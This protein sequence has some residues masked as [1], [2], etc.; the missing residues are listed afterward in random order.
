MTKMIAEYIKG[1]AIC[2]QMKP[3][4]HPTRTPL[5]SISTNPKVKPFSQCLVDFITDLPQVEEYDSIMVIVDH[6]LSKGIS[7]T[8]CSK[9][10]NSEKTAEIFHEKIYSR[11]RIPVKIISD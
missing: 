3:D 2:Q 10:I 9:V 1:Y 4:R 11:Y 6:G 8:P 5:Q 7:L